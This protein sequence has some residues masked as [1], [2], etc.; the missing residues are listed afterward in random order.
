MLHNEDKSIN[1]ED[2]AFE[3]TCYVLTIFVCFLGVSFCYRDAVESLDM[4]F[5]LPKL[6]LLTSDGKKCVKIKGVIN[7]VTFFQ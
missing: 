6:W 7:G 2:D 5:W 4:G 3:A 1:K